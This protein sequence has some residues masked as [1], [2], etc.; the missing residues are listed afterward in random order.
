ML[1]QIIESGEAARAMTLKRALAGVF[2][3]VSGEVFAAS[4]TQVAGRKVRAK[5]ALTLLLLRRR[6]TTRLA[7]LVGIVITL[8]IVVHVVV[9]RGGVPG[10]TGCRCLGQAFAT[11]GHGGIRTRI[12][13]GRTFRGDRQPIRVGTGSRRTVH[14]VV[15]G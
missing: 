14:G 12:S 6:R 3:N 5:E 13:V 7:L 9:G 4:E 8:G 15:L 1:A 2:A 11:G 10:V